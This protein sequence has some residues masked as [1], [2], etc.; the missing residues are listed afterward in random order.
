MASTYENNL[1]LNEMGTGDQ[2]GTWGQVTN[3][4]L[5]LIGEAFSYQTEAT[6]DSDGNKTA[7]IGDGVS[8]KYRAMYI[9]V[10]STTSLSATRTLNIAPNTVSKMFIIENATTGG[11][12]ISVSQGSGANVTIANGTAKVVFTDGG[13]TGAIVYD[14]FDKID[15]G[16]NAKLNGSTFVT[17]ASADT[18]TNKSIDSANNTIT[19]IVDADIK[20]D[21]A[22]DASKIAD[23]TISN[24]EF[25]YLNGASS[26][27]QSQLDGKG[28]ITAVVAGS[29]LTG[30]ATSG[31]A[32][33]AVASSPTFSG[34]V[35]AAAFNGPISTT[36]TVQ[37]NLIHN[38][39]S[40][41]YGSSSSTVNR[42][43]DVLKRDI[44]LASTGGTVTGYNW[45]VLG[46]NTRS[47]FN[48]TGTSGSYIYLPAGTWY[49]TG[50][51]QLSR[52]AS[53]TADTTYMW[54]A[55]STSPNTHLIDG[56]GNAIGDWSTTF[57]KAEST[58]TLSSAAYIGIRF[59]AAEAVSYGYVSSYYS[60][61]Y[62]SF[63]HLAAWKMY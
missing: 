33:L 40:G 60:N 44:R 46:T 61:Q 12:S 52:V 29:N 50:D 8:D 56:T 20:S 53:D 31:S 15:L 9:K 11:Q 14:G 57:F 30:G 35:S 43:P 23:G 2:S 63:A 7:T 32:T 39:S 28:D 55:T 45:H 41:F 1:R 49:I 58:V 48:G 4:N 22:I 3:T 24:A 47:G 5:D 26:N 51:C 38:S 18:L 54:L 36:S 16:T 59:Y 34:T 19:N 6:F 42:A 10:T 27:I 13:G 21:A 17:T 62:S 25:Q 37:G